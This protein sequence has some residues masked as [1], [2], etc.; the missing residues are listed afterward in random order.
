[1]ECGSVRFG[2]VGYGA[3]WSAAVRFGQVW[4][5]VDCGMVWLGKVW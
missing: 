1:M 5:G 3:V 4:F 2:K